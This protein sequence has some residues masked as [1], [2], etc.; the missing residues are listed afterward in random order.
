MNA[1]AHIIRALYGLVAVCAF[2]GFELTS[3]GASYCV[4]SKAVEVYRAAQTH[5]SKLM[6]L[7][8]HDLSADVPG[9][10]PAVVWVDDPLRIPSQWPRRWPEPYFVSAVRQQDTCVLDSHDHVV[11]A[12]CSESTASEWAYE[13]VRTVFRT[14]VS[15][16]VVTCSPTL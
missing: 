12:A 2:H 11:V 8:G 6:A 3:R 10:L 7:V 4:S 15:V 1:T 16:A 14:D 13:F 5:P 9:A